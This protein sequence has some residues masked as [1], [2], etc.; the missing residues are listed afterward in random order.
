MTA[1]GISVAAGQ[2][3]WQ[4]GAD[5]Y[6]PDSDGYLPIH[7]AAKNGS[8][9][10]L[11]YFIDLDMDINETDENGFT[12][13]HHALCHSRI[14][15]TFNKI[16]TDNWQVINYLLNNGAEYK[17]LD[18]THQQV[19]LPA[20]KSDSL[21]LLEIMV[22][23]GA[24]LNVTDSRGETLLA[25]ATRFNAIRVAEYLLQE[26][27]P[28]DD[29]G[30]W[31][32]SPLIIACKN[33]NMP[34]IRLL[35]EFGADKNFRLPLYDFFVDGGEMY[36]G[37]SPFHFSAKFNNIQLASL[38]HEY[39]A[40]LD[41]PAANDVT[42]LHLAVQSQHDSMVEFLINA[43]SDLN[44]TNKWGITPMHQ[45]VQLGRIDY[46]EALL[47]AG[48]GLNIAD[49][50]RRYPIDLIS[51][52]GENSAELLT[53][54]KAH[55]GDINQPLED[56]TSK[57]LDPEV[58]NF[59][60]SQGH[61][62]GGDKTLLLKAVLE[63]DS[64]EVVRILAL[65]GDPNY[66]DHYQS[67]PLHHAIRLYY[68]PIVNLLLDN[69]AEVNVRNSAGD[70]PLHHAVFL[71]SE[72]IT[73]RLLDLGADV[74]A[75]TYSSKYSSK[76]VGMRPPRPPHI[77]GS[78]YRDVDERVLTEDGQPPLYNLF[79]L[80]KY[81]GYL[82]H[83]DQRLSIMG[84]FFERDV[85]LNKPFKVGYMNQRRTTTLLEEALRGG[86]IEEAELLL[87]NG[88]EIDYPSNPTPLLIRFL[89]LENKDLVAQA[90]ELLLRYDANPDVKDEY[91]NTPLYVVCQNVRV[92]DPTTLAK[93][94]IRHGANVRVR[95]KNKETPLHQA[96]YRGYHEIMRALIANGANQHWT[97]RSGRSALSIAVSNSDSTAKKI[98]EISGN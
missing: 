95:C 10:V 49:N 22:E 97:D 26:E 21:D 34:F 40:N 76:H 58:A 18:Y 94:L 63:H 19:F 45:S 27:I 73:G 71:P 14:F 24:D 36:S 57:S 79:R 42:P 41:L 93:I 54:L 51:A 15:N 20:I 39:G 2:G 85:E 96:T 32:G 72:E 12:V 88:A 78:S 46:V 60:K 69:G 77:R 87:K 25:Q 52:E 29:G 44:L 90:L 59:L 8:L 28:I 65:G 31:S 48:A 4:Y 3:E 30:Y 89:L 86:Y 84:L 98:L 9:E 70:T 62:V 17:L 35:L 81:E 47:S 37:Y 82:E 80:S 61:Y 50:Q 38:L 33:Q 16:Q 5:I 43:G 92:K 55:H 74:N 11:K 6:L 1:T 23:N 67:T 68:P 53:L 64:T 56:D 7:L 83:R 75:L 13:L 91:K 66:R